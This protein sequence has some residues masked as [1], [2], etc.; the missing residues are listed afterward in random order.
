MNDRI[1]Q[2]L[3]QMS[4][5]EEE[6]RVALHEQE[7]SL[8]FQIKG[9]RVEFEQAIRQ[10]HRR[11]KTGFFRWLVTYR[12]QNLVTGTI[13]CGMIVPLA[14]LDLSVSFCQATCFPI[15]GVA[16]VARADYLVFDGSS[17]N[18]SISSKNSTAPIAPMAAA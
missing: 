11:L 5:L 3:V 9:K 18:V 13:I 17:S 15:C 16:R 7:T 6:L 12:P 2:L 4:A 14:I 10:A 1:Q 8:L